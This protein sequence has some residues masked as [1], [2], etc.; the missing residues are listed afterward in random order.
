MIIF[1]FFW[2]TFH[3]FRKNFE[4][5]YHRIPFFFPGITSN[6]S[7]QCQLLVQCT[8]QILQLR[9]LPLSLSPLQFWDGNIKQLM[10]FEALFEY[11]INLYGTFSH[12]CPSPLSLK[13]LDMVLKFSSSIN[14]YVLKSNKAITENFKV[15]K[16]APFLRDV[17][18]ALNNVEWV[19]LWISILFSIPNSV[20][21]KYI[22]KQ[23]FRPHVGVAEP[24]TYIWEGHI[25]FFFF[26][27][28]WCVYEM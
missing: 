27:F 5:W 22:T 3:L 16:K 6:S 25:N 9:W 7:C 19:L 17:K 15:V 23:I 10:L 4:I 20:Q 2:K 26:F 12:V 13:V 18:K 1:F 11:L 21:L 8:M 28:F 24:G 14:Y